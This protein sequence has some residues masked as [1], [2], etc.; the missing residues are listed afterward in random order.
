MINSAESAQAA[1]AQVIA[2][3][4]REREKAL[5]TREWKHRL[6]GYG[7]GIGESA[8]GP[9]IESLPRRIPICA[10]PSDIA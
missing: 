7:Y 9:V 3:A 10:L 4:R 6:A 1:A 8:F 5:S 2:I